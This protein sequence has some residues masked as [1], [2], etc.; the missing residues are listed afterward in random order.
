MKMINNFIKIIMP[1]KIYNYFFYYYN[2]F[3]KLYLP[4]KLNLKSPKTFNEKILWLKMYYRYPEANKLADKYLVREYIKKTIGEKYLIPLIGVYDDAKQID[5]SK[6]P[7]SFVM[8]P[9]HASGLILFVK[10]KRKLDELKCKKM[11]NKW[12]KLDYYK[13]SKSYEYKDIKP[14]ILCEEYLE[15]SREY[16]LL[17]YK[18]FCFNGEP[19]YI[20]VDFDRFVN[21]TRAFYDINWNKQPFTLFY[22][23]SIKELPRPKNFDEMIYVARTLSKDMKFVR[24]DLYNIEGRIYFGEITF[25]HGGGFETVYPKEYNVYLGQLIKL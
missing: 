1:E 7:N 22:P 10:D 14:R 9:N 6:L 18:F 12:L 21:H 17:D 4:K 2:H 3:K 24:I 8:K 5:F 25:H 15:G 13:L 20:Q 11:L 16:G 19:L 23:L